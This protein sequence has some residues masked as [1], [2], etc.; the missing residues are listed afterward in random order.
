LIPKKT[1]TQELQNQELQKDSVNINS[2]KKDDASLKESAKKENAKSALKTA[3]KT[4]KTVAGGLLGAAIGAVGFSAVGLA[5]LPVIYLKMIGKSDI[6]KN[7][8]LYLPMDVIL[9][10]IM[11][12]IGGLV[13]GA[14]RSYKENP[15]KAALDVVKEVPLYNKM[16]KNLTKDIEEAEGPMVKNLMKL[17]ALY[18][19]DYIGF[20]M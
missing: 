10:P 11:G 7:L 13:I 3:Y 16:L 12:A 5:W 15:G 2:I 18:Y 20:S 9:H 6:A 19:G 4:L 17:I 14:L 1:L 8:F